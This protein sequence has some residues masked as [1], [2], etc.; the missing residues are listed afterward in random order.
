[1]KSEAQIQEIVT[2]LLTWFDLHGRRFPW[3]FKEEGYHVLVTEFLLQRTRASTALI[4]Y[5][6]FFKLYPTL[7]RLADVNETILTQFFSPFGLEYRG[8]RLS[9]LAKEIEERYE[10]KV[11]CDLNELLRLHG[12]GVYI[13]SAVLNFA[14]RL[15]TPVVDKNVM[16]VLNRHF[17]I[18]RES[19]GRNLVSSMYIHGDNRKLAYALI[20]VG[21]IACLDKE[22]KCPLGGFLPSY[23]LQKNRWRMLRKVVKEDGSVAL[24]EQ[25]VVSSRRAA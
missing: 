18:V 16:R 19:D 20:D 2:S 1:M 12:V 24:R 25:P 17:G 8:A 21:A 3:R 10:G 15:P 6:K 14:C 5:T 4:A 13:A 7:R 23:P 22:C 11:P 9:E